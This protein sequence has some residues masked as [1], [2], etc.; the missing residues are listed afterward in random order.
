[1][2]GKSRLKASGKINADTVLINESTNAEL[3]EFSL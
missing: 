2:T 3:E 1:M